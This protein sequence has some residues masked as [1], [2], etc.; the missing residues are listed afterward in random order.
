VRVS[1]RWERRTGSRW[2]YRLDGRV[3]EQNGKG[4]GELIARLS[5]QMS[6]IKRCSEFPLIAYECDNDADE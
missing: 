6:Q 2:V 3:P 5:C 4:R 1:L